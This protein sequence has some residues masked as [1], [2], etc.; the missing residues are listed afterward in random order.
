MI[1][2]IANAKHAADQVGD[3]LGG[4]QL[5]AKAVGHG[6][7]QKQ[8]EQPPVLRGREPRRPAG[9]GPDLQG[10]L[11]PTATGVAPAHHR[12]RRTPQFPSNVVEGETGIQQL[13]GQMTAGFQAV[14]RAF[15]A[16]GGLRVE[17]LYYCITYAEV[18]K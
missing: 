15:R 1:A 5:R 8:A 6:P 17:A 4:P 18:N 2:M 14:G 7:L 9:R 3:P 12:A 11:A 10:P 16:H 13:Q